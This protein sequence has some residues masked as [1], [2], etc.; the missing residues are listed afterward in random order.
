[1]GCGCNS[2]SGEQWQ[3]VK[4]DGTSSTP[5]TKAVAEAARNAEGGYI[6]QVK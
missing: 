6:R 1:M 4:P 5:T 3:H 2:K